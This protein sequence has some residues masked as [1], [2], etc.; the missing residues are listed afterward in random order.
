MAKQVEPT[1]EEKAAADREAAIAKEAE[2]IIANTRSF[3]SGKTIEK[4][5][6]IPGKDSDALSADEKAAKEK[7][8]ADAL[9]KE[10]ELE[11]ETPLVHVKVKTDKEETE[12]DRIKAFNDRTGFQ[13]TKWED[14]YDKAE[15]IEKLKAGQEEFSAKRKLEQ[16][17]FTL[18]QQLPVPV[19]QVVNAVLKNEDYKKVGKEVFTSDI[20][21]NMTFRDYNDKLPLVLKY[22]DITEEEYS[23]LEDK[24]KGI[25]EK[26]AETAYNADRTK[27]I[28]GLNDWKKTREK[29]A[30]DFV[31]SI[32]KT[33]A[34]LDTEFPHM[35]KADKEAIK[36]KLIKGVKPELT[37]ENGYYKEDASVKVAYM[38]HGKQTVHTLMSNLE[39]KIQ[40]EADKKAKKLMAEELELQNRNR[41]DK[42]DL[43]G[44]GS[45]REPGDAEQIRKRSNEAL[46]T[47]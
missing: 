7:E 14:L 33:M 15:D 18:F 3:L 24:Q 12:A 41:N 21:L 2:N 36:D 8:A 17:Y 34:Q 23:V 11:I 27:F 19:K 32:D 30:E 45:K 35:K 40:Q 37:D 43:G 13:I 46:N 4:E 47:K 16:G 6:E 29:Q 31:T 26:A 25:I 38:V 42:Q 44:G 5:I 28:N 10:T 22:T 39:T 1:A 9:A 20:D